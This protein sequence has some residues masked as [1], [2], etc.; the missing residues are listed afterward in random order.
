MKEQFIFAHCLRIQ[1]FILG[2]P[3]MQ[4]HEASVHNATALVGFMCQLD[5]SYSHLRGMSFNWGNAFTRSRCKDLVIILGFLKLIVFISRTSVFFFSRMKL[6]NTSC[7]F[8]EECLWTLYKGDKLW[9]PEIKLMEGSGNEFSGQLL[10]CWVG[11]QLSQALEV[12]YCP[13]WL[14]YD[15]CIR[16]PFIMSLVYNVPG[17]GRQ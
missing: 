16:R 14:T 3:W 6:R 5:S 15:K 1:S 9:S 11:V 10:E 7:N 13:M 17:C 8:S 12:Y 4:K 2:T